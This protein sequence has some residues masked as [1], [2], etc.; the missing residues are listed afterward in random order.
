MKSENIGIS[1]PSTPVIIVP[2]STLVF[3]RINWWSHEIK[4][5]LPPE[6]MLQEDK[7]T[8]I[9]WN[10]QTHTT[11]FLPHPKTRPMLPFC[12]SLFSSAAQDP[13][14]STASQAQD[15]LLPQGTP[16]CLVPTPFAPSFQHWAH[17]SLAGALTTCSLPHSGRTDLNM[18]HTMHV[19]RTRAPW[20]YLLKCLP[21][22]KFST[23][24]NLSSRFIKIWIWPMVLELAMICQHALQTMPSPVL[25]H[26]HIQ[27]V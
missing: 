3:C 21:T 11:T 5:W 8:C 15:P 16:V 25:A 12:F 2:L 13:T 26:K 1:N 4:L 10:I 23:L 24:L 7:R 27:I 17:S 19:S 9:G 20:G 6:E 18:T 22:F 14:V